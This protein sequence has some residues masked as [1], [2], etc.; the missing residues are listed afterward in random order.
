MITFPRLRQQGS[1]LVM[2][3]FVI[4]VLSF[5]GVTMVNLLSSSNQ[6]VVY[7]VLGARAKMAAQSGVQRLLTT[8][9][10]LNASIAD[11]SVTISS[12]AAFSS[13]SGLENCSYQATC[14][15]TQVVKKN[16]NYNY[17]RFESTGVCQANDIWASRTFE[18]DA[19]EER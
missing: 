8:A 9:F 7:E 2:T 12:P 6:A 16:V 10:P 11:C 5:L 13:G 1:M 15:T 14:T 19:F 4:I 3:L 17:Y 18:L